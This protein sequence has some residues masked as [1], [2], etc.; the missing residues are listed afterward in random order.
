MVTHT[1]VDAVGGHAE[2]N[3][4]DRAIADE[5]AALGHTMTAEEI[6]KTFEMHNVW[7]T[8]GERK[9]TTAA[10]CEHCAAITRN[11]QVT[12]SLYK[13]EFKAEGGVSGEINV[14]QH[15]EISTPRPTGGPS[16]TEPV[17]EVTPKVEVPVVGAVPVEEPAAASGTGMIVTTVAVVGAELVIH[18]LAGKLRGIERENIRRGWRAA[19]V[20]KF[21][22][23]IESLHRGWRYNPQTRPTEQ[24]YLVVVYG[25]SFEEQPYSR[26][27]WGGPVYLYQQMDYLRSH[28]STTPLN[29]RLDPPYDPSNDQSYNFPTRQVF[30]VSIPVWPERPIAT[31]GSGQR[32]PIAT[33]GSGQRIPVASGPRRPNE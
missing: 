7:L 10:R 33:G 32:I 22:G 6:G 24:T 5:Q 26:F 29:E 18:H 25:I 1:A 30:A 28:I 11:V 23:T 20:P 27:I 13:A 31:G 4:L 12:E 3:A 15:G 9:L 19:V 17:A 16:G 21:A 2:V 14:P 8:G